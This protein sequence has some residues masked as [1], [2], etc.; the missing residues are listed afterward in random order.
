MTPKR[1]RRQPP[2]QVLA[3]DAP[4]TLVG[5]GSVIHGEL[6]MSGNVLIHGRIEGIIFTDGEVRVAPEG[7]VEGGIHARRVAL[8]GYCHGKLEATDEVTL[9][10][11][12]VMRGDIDAR[13]LTVDPKARFVGDWKKSEGPTVPKKHPYQTRPGR[14]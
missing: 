3:E 11:G 2:A 9:Y 7:M 14:A 4:W 12:A 10:P 1:V 13:I 8:E 6:V 5:P